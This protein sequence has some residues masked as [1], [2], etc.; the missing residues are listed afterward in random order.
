[1]YKN[2]VSTHISIVFA[3]SQQ[4]W[5]RKKTPIEKKCVSLHAE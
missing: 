1:M 2:M 4:L 3:E 5:E